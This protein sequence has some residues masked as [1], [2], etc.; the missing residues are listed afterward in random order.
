LLWLCND[1][2][3]LCIFINHPHDNPTHSG[4]STPIS[5][6]PPYLGWEASRV[7]LVAPEVVPDRVPSAASKASRGPSVAPSDSSSDSLYIPEY[8]FPV[9]GGT[10]QNDNALQSQVD[11]EEWNWVYGDPDDESSQG[12]SIAGPV[13]A[14]ILAEQVELRQESI[15]FER[16]PGF[17]L[18]EVFRE[19][20]EVSEGGGPVSM[21]DYDGGD[22]RM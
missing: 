8:F 15:S 14:E 3:H 16:M 5:A 11:K 7:P 1:A 17:D 19:P 13:L 2:F 12:G 6:T 4:S 10:S 9:N 18:G 21:V 20:D 22:E